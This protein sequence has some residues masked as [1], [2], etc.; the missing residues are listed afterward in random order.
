MWTPANFAL[1]SLASSTAVVAT[2]AGGLPQAIEDGVQGSLVPERDSTALAQAIG[3]LLGQPAARKA[4]GEAARARM[5]REFGWARV[6]E[7]FA[8]A[9]V[10]AREVPPVAH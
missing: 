10:R 1:E 7:R 2:T 9:Y 5:L 6:A 4:L 8:A 3:A